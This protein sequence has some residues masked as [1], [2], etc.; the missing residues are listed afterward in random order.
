M[1]YNEI[2][3]R[4]QVKRSC[5]DKAQCICPSHN[6]KEASLTISKGEKGTV[7]HCH[8]GCET[9]D[10]LGAV[11]LSLKDLF[12]DDPIQTGERWRAYV[13]GRE[14]RKIEDVYKYVDLN[15][16]Y[17]FTRIRLSGKKFI[18]G[19]MDAIGELTSEGGHE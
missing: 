9:A 7:V 18:Y 10:I 12:D 1:T 11:G 19:I 15:G 13:E 16:N 6:D 4:F 17:A 5:R 8:A 3:S 14:K 2:L